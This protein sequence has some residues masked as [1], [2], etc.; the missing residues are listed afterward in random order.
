MREAIIIILLVVVGLGLGYL[1]GG[2]LGVD[3]GGPRA[4]F[5]V[6]GI[7]IVGAV[8]KALGFAPASSRLR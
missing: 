3:D 1:V 4:L 7:L 2:A 5:A 8:A 6:L